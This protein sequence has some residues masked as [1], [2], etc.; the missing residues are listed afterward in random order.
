VLAYEYVLTYECV[1]TGPLSAVERDERDDRD[2]SDEGGAMQ[3]R[4]GLGELRD[5]DSDVWVEERIA[6]VH[7]KVPSLLA[8]LV[9][10]YKC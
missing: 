1:R 4:D 2:G 8:L 5:E 10:K 9:Q 7:L 6:H 3:E